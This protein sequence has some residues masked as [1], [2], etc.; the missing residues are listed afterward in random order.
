MLSRTY[1]I[2]LKDPSETANNQDVSGFRP[3]NSQSSASALAFMLR[4]QTDKPV[5]LEERGVSLHSTAKAICVNCL[6]IYLDTSKHLLTTH[7]SDD[8]TRGTPRNPGHWGLWKSLVPI[9]ISR[10]PGLF[11]VFHFGLCSIIS[12]VLVVFA[13][14]T[15]LPL[16]V[17]I[18]GDG[19]S[20]ETRLWSSGV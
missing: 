4:D 1:W 12:G 16:W 13:F 2:L 10:F 18:A 3:P 19:R 17:G 20:R 6:C 11:I 9:I 5:S 7:Q 15:T 8:I 14:S